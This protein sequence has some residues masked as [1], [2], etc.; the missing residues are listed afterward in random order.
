MI[1]LVDEL[2]KAY[3]GDAWH[4][5]NTVTLLLNAD[6]SKVFTHPIPGA[7]SIAELV[8][9]LTAWT[10]EV[11]ERLNGAKAKEPIRGDWPTPVEQSISEWELIINDFKKANEKL[12]TIVSDFSP[13]AW[14][15]EVIDERNPALGTGV[16]Y[17][18]LLNGLIQ[19]HAYHSGQMALL[20][21]F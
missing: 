10:E 8:L 19:H 1:N 5:N 14:A 20:S 2:Q 17:S 13:E 3:N 12:V 6:P 11:V 15:A 4:G 21:K 18:Q 16:D 7:H 9:H